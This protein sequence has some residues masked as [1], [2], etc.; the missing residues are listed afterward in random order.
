MSDTIWDVP[1]GLPLPDHDPV[2]GK[3]NEPG[4]GFN[5]GIFADLA[6]QIGGLATQVKRHQ[7]RL[8]RI[9]RSLPSD[10]QYAVPGIY[11]AS[12][13]LALDLGSPAVGTFWNV[14]RIIVGGSD[15]TTEPDGVA[16][17]FVQGSN[18]I[19]AGANP[20]IAQAADLTVN[21]LPQRSFYG[22]HQL[23]VYPPE[24]LWVII[25]SGT[26]ATQYVASM[27]VEEYDLAAGAGGVIEE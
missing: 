24:H 12:G 4:G 19:A 18:P 13:S 20:S 11:P 22:T 17:V 27:K 26:A 5:L 8:E 1:A 3:L 14:R 25:T 23:V 9:A 21:A 6:L 7:D 10:Y 16:W 15:I 2:S